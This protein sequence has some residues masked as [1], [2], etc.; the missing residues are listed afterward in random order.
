MVRGR[1]FEQEKQKRKLN[2]EDPEDIELLEHAEE[3]NPRTG[4]PQNFSKYVKRLIREEIQRK[5]FQQQG[6]NN[7]N[8]DLT[9]IDV[10]NDDDETYTLEVKNAMSSFL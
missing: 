2:E 3:I 1:L 10:P 5:K 6:G 8:S 4:K 9:I 7:N